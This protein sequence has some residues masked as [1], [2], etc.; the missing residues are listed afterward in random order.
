MS[1]RIHQLEDA[2]AIAHRRYDSEGTHP[3]LSDELLSVRQG[4]QAQEHEGTKVKHSEPDPSRGMGTLTIDSGGKSRYY[5]TSGASESLL[6]VSGI[7]CIHC[8]CAQNIYRK[9][10]R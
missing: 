1:K 9:E 7:R 6:L 5:G 10:R 4:P 8:F 2:L 3:L